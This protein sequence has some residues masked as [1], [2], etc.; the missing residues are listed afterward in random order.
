MKP[1]KIITKQIMAYNKKLYVKWNC[2][3]KYFE[4]WYKRLKGDVLITPIVESIY[5]DRGS[6]FKYEKLDRRIIDWLYSSDSFKHTKKWKWIGRKRYDDR[7]Y[8]DSVKRRNMFEN[9]AKDNYN[10][11]NSEFINPLM[12]TS[13]WLAPDMQT[14]NRISCRSPENIRKHR[15][16]QSDS[17]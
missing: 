11:T 5:N 12:E 7:K 10:L 17:Y 16:Q 8:R 2:E 9:I 6:C 4:V 13:D 15:E 3:D 14:R 1:N